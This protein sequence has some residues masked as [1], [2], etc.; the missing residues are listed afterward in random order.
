MGEFFS[1]LGIAIFLIVIVYGDEIMTLFA[2]RILG[3]QGAASD[4]LEQENE[5]LR[6]KADSGTNLLR[7]IM[8]DNRAVLPRELEQ[9]VQAH[10]ITY[11]SKLGTSLDKNEK[12]L[13]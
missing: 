11:P 6:L 10:L 12:K 3:R 13:K 4:E 7:A 1:L 2:A 8:A 9:S 5:L